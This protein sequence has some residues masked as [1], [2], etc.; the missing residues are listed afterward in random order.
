M[1]NEQT[2]CSNEHSIKLK[3]REPWMHTLF[4]NIMAVS[5]LSFAQHVKMKSA[6]AGGQ[7]LYRCWHITI[8]WPGYLA[9]MFAILPICIPVGCFVLIFVPFRG[10]QLSLIYR[11]R[12]IINSNA[13]NIR[14]VINKMPINDRCVFLR[15]IPPSFRKWIF[16]YVS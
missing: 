12:C 9:N 1:V 6:Q 14:E 10:N 11:Y 16:I 8:D 4:C 3:Q 5:P 7:S 2:Q 13:S 15:A